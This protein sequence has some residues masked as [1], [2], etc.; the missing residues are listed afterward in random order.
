M[1]V[2]DIGT[3]DGV[4]SR[5]V[6]NA[7]TA[8]DSIELLFIKKDLT[9]CFRFEVAVT[10]YVFFDGVGSSGTIHGIARREGDVVKRDQIGIQLA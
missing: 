10:C 2:T 3:A 9:F 6:G 4:L 5:Y 7:S 8:V 1:D